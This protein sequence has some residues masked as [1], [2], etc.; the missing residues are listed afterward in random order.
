[1]TRFSWSDPAS[2]QTPGG[3]FWTDGWDGYA[4]ARQRLLDVVARQQVPGVVVLGGDVHANY[5]ADLKA[6]FEDP[7]APVCATE[8]CGTSISSLGLAQDRVDAARAFNPLV[9]HARTDQRG[10]VRFRIRPR[11]LQ[12]ALQVVADARQAS[13]PLQTQARFVVDADKPG[14][15][16]A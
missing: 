10:Y 5:V 11:Q 1:M 15:V 13:S 3:T 12:A 14:A 7:R 16:R 9:H 6:D 8:F 4:P 2:S